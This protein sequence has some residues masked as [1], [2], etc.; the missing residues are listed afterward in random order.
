MASALAFTLR[1]PA[2]APVAVGEAVLAGT[3]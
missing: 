3:R 2:P 1:P